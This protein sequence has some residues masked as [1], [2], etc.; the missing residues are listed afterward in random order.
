VVGQPK[1]K[2]VEKSVGKMNDNPRPQISFFSFLLPPSVNCRDLGQNVRR[3]F[4]MIYG[5]V[6]D[7]R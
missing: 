4:F 6:L 1:K 7:S 3:I 2:I 5:Q